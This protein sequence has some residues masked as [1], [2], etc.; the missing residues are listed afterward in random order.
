MKDLIYTKT[1]L[2]GLKPKVMPK[3][4]SE[5]IRA[6]LESYAKGE[7]QDVTPLK[8]SDLHRLRHGDWRA[9]LKI[10]AETITVAEI[11]HRREAYR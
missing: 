1:A 9:I 6:K 4:D 2:K 11:K 7:P 8:G 3:A 10:D 5:A